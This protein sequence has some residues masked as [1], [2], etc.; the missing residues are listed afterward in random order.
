[1]LFLLRPGLRSLGSLLSICTSLLD[2][3]LSVGSMLSSSRWLQIVVIVTSILILEVMD[4]VLILIGCVTL[5]KEADLWRLP[6][7]GGR[8]S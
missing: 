3:I 7:L 8:Q 6:T 2:I 4:V 1:M 5:Q